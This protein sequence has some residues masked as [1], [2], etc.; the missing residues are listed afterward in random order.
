MCPRLYVKFCDTTIGNT[1][2]CPI[3]RYQL[4]LEKGACW[5][6]ITRALDY[7]HELILISTHMPSEV[8]DELT[9]PFPILNGC[10][11]AD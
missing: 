7:Q 8:F 5:K 6:N 1:V 9:Y 10:I 11:A 2:A 4:T 3:L